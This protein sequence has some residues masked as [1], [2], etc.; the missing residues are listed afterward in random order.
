MCSDETMEKKVGRTVSGNMSYA[1]LAKIQKLLGH[2]YKAPTM[3]KAARAVSRHFAEMMAA[4]IDDDEFFFNCIPH[5]LRERARK[6]DAINELITNILVDG[7]V[8]GYQAGAADMEHFLNDVERELAM[9]RQS[10]EPKGE[11]QHE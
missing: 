8:M 6:D 11:Q 1:T 4:K 9:Y 3:E 2:S 5:E 7:F 10:D